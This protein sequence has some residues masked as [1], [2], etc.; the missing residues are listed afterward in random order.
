MKHPFEID[1]RFR[2]TNQVFAEVIED[3]IQ[4]FYRIVAEFNS[5]GYD[6]DRIDRDCRTG[7]V[8][9]LFKRRENGV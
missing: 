9:L 6:F 4:D 1:N 5:R 2:G 7:Q 8:T 3:M